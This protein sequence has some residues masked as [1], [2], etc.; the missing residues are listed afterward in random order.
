MKTIL[1][2]TDFSAGAENAVLYANEMAQ[3]MDARLVL[4]HSVFAPAAEVVSYGSGPYT[5]SGKDLAYEDAQK[6]KLEALKSTLESTDWCMPVQYETKLHYGLTKDT[7][8]QIIQELNADL[9]VI[10]NEGADSLKEI[11]VGSV[12]AEI[13]KNATCPVLIIPPK[14]TF[15]PLRKIVFATDLKGEPFLDVHSVINLASL[16]EADI[17]FLHIIPEAGTANEEFAQAELDRLHKQFPY[18]NAT[19]YAEPNAH[20]EEGISQFCRLHHADM[21]VMGYHPRTF[22]QHLFTQD[23]TQEMAYHTY[24]PLLV[25]HY[26]Q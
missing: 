6:R 17:L 26:R 16:F 15:K 22:W 12:A 4:F 1:C 7:I 13:I 18:Q 23:Y 2:P 11:F 14:A 3:Y 25:I 20:I 10:G 8:P 19:F 24:L 9:V 21:L 5:R